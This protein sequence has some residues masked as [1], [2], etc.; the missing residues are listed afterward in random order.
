[1]EDKTHHTEGAETGQITLSFMRSKA[2][3]SSKA[4]TKPVSLIE[5]TREEFK[6]TLK[7]PKQECQE[8]VH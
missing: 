5:M 1:M 6:K 7:R 3:K 2:R 4:E 8:L